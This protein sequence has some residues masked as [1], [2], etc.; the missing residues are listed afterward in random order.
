MK[1]SVREEEKGTILNKKIK[2]EGKFNRGIKQ[3]IKDKQK[4][5]RQKGSKLFKKSVKNKMAAGGRKGEMEA[6]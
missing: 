4:E 5:R 3:G 6:G 1:K 2:G